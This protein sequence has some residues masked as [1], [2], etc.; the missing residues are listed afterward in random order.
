[1]K[2][3]KEGKREEK[4][5]LVVSRLCSAAVCFL[6]CVCDCGVCCMPYTLSFVL[7]HENYDVRPV[8]LCPTD[9]VYSYPIGKCTKGER[10][11][12]EEYI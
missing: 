1:M 5:D 4:K 7:C 12:R 9:K 11:R 8:E 10:E 3:E 2:T 6:C